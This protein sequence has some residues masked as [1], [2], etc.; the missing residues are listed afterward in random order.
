MEDNKQITTNPFQHKYIDKGFWFILIALI[1]CSIISI[2]SASSTLI[3]KAMASGANAY[4]PI[5]SHIMFLVIGAGLAYAIQFLPSWFIRFCGYLGLLFSFVCLIL[6]YVPGLQVSANDA[7]R[8]IKLGPVQFQPSEA[9]KLTLIIVAADLLG[10]I[11]NEKDRKKYFWIVLALT[12][13]ICAPILAGNLSSVVL[14]FGVILLLLFIARIPCKWLLGVVGVVLLVLVCGYF[15]VKFG[16]LERDKELPKPIR[17]ASVW[18]GRIDDFVGNKQV[19][20]DNN[21]IKITDDNYQSVMAE[22]AVARG[23]RS[24]FG[25][26]PGNSVMRNKLPLAYMDFIFAIIVEETGL[27]GAIGLISLYLCI[28]GRACIAT[29]KY[30]DYSA[31]LMVMGLAIML[32]SQAFISMAVAVGL[33]PVTGQP[34]PLISKGGTSILTTCLYFGI[35]MS[36]C[37]EQNMRRD[38]EQQSVKESQ[39]MVP[40]IDTD[41][42]FYPTDNQ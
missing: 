30:A 21:T 25:V 12:A 32:T 23:G 15:I 37:R 6:M 27:F 20:N 31:L 42:T 24:V 5:L 19:G 16:F 4:Q 28:L 8:W 10:R 22:T 40:D 13:V 34:L 26:L 41:D 18:V 11:K 17:R 35:M 14:I 36:V 33:G 2:F 38:I 1:V 9:A 39:D 29:S 3:N 7:V